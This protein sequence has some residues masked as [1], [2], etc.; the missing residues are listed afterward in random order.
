MS[1]TDLLNRPMTLVQRVDM[2]DTDDYGNTVPTET[3]VEVLGE[4][5]QISRDEPDDAGETSDTRWTLFLLA[6]TS[7]KTGDAVICD[8][9]TFEVV[10]DPWHARNPRTGVESHIQATLRRTAG[11]SEEVGS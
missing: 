6:G 8:G 4:L 9:E 11:T 10:G 1:L 7:V 5:Q 3:R 2:G